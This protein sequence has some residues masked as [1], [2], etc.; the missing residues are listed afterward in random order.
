MA[1]RSARRETD[2][3]TFYRSFEDY[4]YYAFR[5]IGIILNSS[6]SSRASIAYGEGWTADHSHDLHLLALKRLTPDART[7]QGT[8]GDIVQRDDECMRQN[9]LKLRNINHPSLIKYYGLHEKSGGV[10]NNGT[11]FTVV[12]EFCAGRLEVTIS[13]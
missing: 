2:D 9:L 5:E 13:G 10:V 11:T 12:A 3:R 6:V 8:N 7:T 4:G 1:S